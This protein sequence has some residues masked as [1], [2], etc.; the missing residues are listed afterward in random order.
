MHVCMCACACAHKTEQCGGK[1]TCVAARSS[2]GSLSRRLGLGEAGGLGWAPS[3]LS[4]SSPSAARPSALGRV[5]ILLRGSHWFIPQAFLEHQFPR[6]C[7]ETRMLLE[8][9]AEW[10]PSEQREE[11]ARAASTRVPSSP[12]ACAEPLQLPP[13]PAWHVRG[14]FPSF[15]LSLAPNRGRAG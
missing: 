15:L 10:L 14:M 1:D 9:V 12:S 6:R 2:K 4:P 11:P 5:L 3:Q 13:P 7:S 8:G